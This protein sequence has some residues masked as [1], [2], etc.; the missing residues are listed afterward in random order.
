[1]ERPIPGQP[2]KATN[3]AELLYEVEVNVRWT[4]QDVANLKAVQ[5][6]KILRRAENAAISAMHE[7]RNFQQALDSAMARTENTLWNW[8]PSVC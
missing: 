7:G 8:N 3:W 5:F 2:S 1:M 6:C 4:L